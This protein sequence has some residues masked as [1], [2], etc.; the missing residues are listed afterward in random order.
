MGLVDSLNE[1]T[2]FFSPAITG[3]MP[4]V[5]GQNRRCQATCGQ[6]QFRG[7]RFASVTNHAVAIAGTVAA[8]VYDLN[9]MKKRSRM[10]QQYTR[11]SLSASKSS[12]TGN[13]KPRW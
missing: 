4:S 10:S 11:L 1:V 12:S 7:G 2:E 13:D 8:E 5:A 9:V 3:P 6:Q